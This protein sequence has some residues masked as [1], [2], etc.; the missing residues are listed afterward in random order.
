MIP[1]TG[2]PDPNQMP[3]QV[4]IPPQ[5]IHPPH[6][7]TIDL[8]GVKIPAEMLASPAFWVFLIVT[9]LTVLGLAWIKYGR[10]K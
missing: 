2:M 1:Y 10:S 5:E 3:Q 8:L 7:M 6:D 9:S 4:L